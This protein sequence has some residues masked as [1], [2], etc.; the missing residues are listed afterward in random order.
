MHAAERGVFNINFDNIDFTTYVYVYWMIMYEFFGGDELL[1]PNE[2]K[3]LLT[4]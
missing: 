3:K 2:R 4:I 1:K